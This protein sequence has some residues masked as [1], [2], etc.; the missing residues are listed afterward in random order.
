MSCGLLETA[1]GARTFHFLDSFEGMPP[2]DEIDGNQARE[3]ERD[4]KGFRYFDN[5]RADVDE[6][7]ALVRKVARDDQ[8][9][10]IHKGWFAETLR[11]FPRDCAIAVLRLDGDWYEST[12]SCLENLYDQV[13][14][15]GIVIIDD[16]LDWDGCTRAVH[17]FLSSRKAAE[18]IRQTKIGGVYNIVKLPPEALAPQA[19]FEMA[20]KI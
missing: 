12:M 4:T 13:L 7:E 6:F 19:A 3:W 1:P 8:D 5:L 14:P 17:D 10:H 2:V 18:G 11:D 16:Y 15:G 20:G 9:V